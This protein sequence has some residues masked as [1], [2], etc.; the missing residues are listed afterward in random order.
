MI[1]IYISDSQQHNF[2]YDNIAAL[3]TYLKMISTSS[4]TMMLV[5]IWN[6][7]IRKLSYQTPVRLIF[8]LLSHPRDPSS[9]RFFQ[10]GT[11][12]VPKLPGDQALTAKDFPRRGQSC[13][14][15]SH[16]SVSMQWN[17]NDI[18]T[19]KQGQPETT[20]VSLTVSRYMAGGTSIR[21]SWLSQPV[22][23]RQE[24]TTSLPN[25]D[26]VTNTLLSDW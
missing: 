7:D 23:K 8:Q 12:K 5:V 11:S 14:A 9:S 24:L 10:D 17:Q 15:R 22:S 13:E 4:Y 19:N 16:P 6:T 1:E 20:T 25:L 26:F 2:R 18:A 3:K 21:S